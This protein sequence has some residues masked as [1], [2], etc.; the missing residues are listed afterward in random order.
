MNCKHCGY[1]YPAN[2][3]A[4]W[5]G[6]FDPPGYF[7]YLAAFSVLGTVVL[8]VFGVP[9]WR[10]VALG[11]TVI[12]AYQVFMAWGSCRSS[13]NFGNEGEHGGICPKCKGENKVRPW[14][15]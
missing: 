4:S 8:F 3:L 12:L 11:I 2:R 9:L 6:G 13:G 15:F 1:R 14:S 7:F 10:W 5:P